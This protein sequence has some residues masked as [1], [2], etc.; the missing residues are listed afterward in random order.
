[1]QVQQ[2][3]AVVVLDGNNVLLLFLDAISDSRIADKLHDA[4]LWQIYFP[5]IL[6]LADLRSGCPPWEI[7]VFITIDLK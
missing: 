2:Q 6:I 5:C 1:M 3:D 4:P 7:R